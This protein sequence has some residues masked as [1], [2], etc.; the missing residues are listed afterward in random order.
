M[1]RKRFEHSAFQPNEN[2]RHF[3]DEEEDNITLD[4]ETIPTPQVCNNDGFPTDRFGDGCNW[5][6]TYWKYCGLADDE[7]FTSSICCGCQEKVEAVIVEEEID[8]SHCNN[9]DVPTNND[10]EGCDIM[11]DWPDICFIED[12]PGEFDSADCCGCQ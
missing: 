3:R 9:L 6:Y 2:S 1:L 8:Y 10:G 7:T 4:E 11:L 12:I 5:Y